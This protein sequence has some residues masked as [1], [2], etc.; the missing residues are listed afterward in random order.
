VFIAEDSAIHEKYKRSTKLIVKKGWEASEKFNETQLT[1]DYMYGS[2]AY[3]QLVSRRPSFLLEELKYGN[4][5]Y[6]DTDT[7]LRADPRPYFTG[8]FDFWARRNSHFRT[9]PD[10]GKPIF[11]TGFMALRA[12]ENTKALVA[13]WKQRLE[14]G[15]RGQVNQGAFNKSVYNCSVAKVLRGKALS[16]ELFPTGDRYRTYTQEVRDKVVMMHNNFCRGGICKQ[17]RMEEYGLWNPATREA[18]L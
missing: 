12:T 15:K 6:I 3:M 10:A 18:A 13:D 14:I 11:C 4:V 2:R 9:G 8:A 5:L 7:V 17:N 1:S 16:E